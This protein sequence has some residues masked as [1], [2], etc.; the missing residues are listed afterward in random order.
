MSARERRSD[1][2]RI[3]TERDF[4][5]G[6][7]WTVLEFW[8]A[9]QSPSMR[10]SA[11]R[12]SGLGV[13]KA[14]LMIAPFAGLLAPIGNTDFGS[15]V[16]TQGLAGDPLLIAALLCFVGGAAGQVW[17]LLHWWRTGRHRDSMWVA[18]SAVALGASA[19]GLWWFTTFLNPVAY[20]TLAPV[21]VVTALLG[22]VGLVAQLVGSRGSEGA[23]QQ[24]KDEARAARLRALPA[25]EQH[26][27]LAERH[28]IVAVLRERGLVDEPTAQRA[29]ALPLGDWYVLD[30]E[31]RARR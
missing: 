6:V 22:G 10:G 15:S 8:Q 3:A 20:A 16:E 1:A 9:R 31:R 19:I 18:S 21:L 27:I 17:V 5:T 12:G 28:E 24:S 13:L 29:L 26:A 23:L 25:E 11:N 30:Q 14:V 4:S 7:D 2:V